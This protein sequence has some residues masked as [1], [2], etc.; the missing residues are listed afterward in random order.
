MEK[1]VVENVGAVKRLEIPVP[2]G[3]GVV[4]F[5]GRNGTGKSTTISAVSSLLQGKGAPLPTLRDGAEKGSV[6]GFGAC[7]NLSVESRRRGGA[8]E[9]VVDNVEGKFSIDKLVDPD[10]QSPEAADR[11]RIKALVTLTGKKADYHDFLELFNSEDEF[12]EI[13]SPASLETNDPVEMGRRIKADLDKSAKKA[14]TEAERAQ[15]EADILFATCETFDKNDIIADEKAFQQTLST[16]FDRKTSLKT[17][18]QLY[19]GRRFEVERA[20]RNIAETDVLEQE[21]QLKKCESDIHLLESQNEDSKN[22][23]AERKEWIR[24]AENTIARLRQEVQSEEAMMASREG[25]ITSHRRTM[26]S[27]KTTLQSLAGWR[28]IIEREK[29]LEPVSEEEVT[30]AEKEYE[31]LREKQYRSDKAKRI[32]EEVE[33]AK[34]V[35]DESQ[36]WRDTATTLRSMGRQC[37]LIL[38][39]L[40]GEDCPIRIVDGRL[41]VETNRGMTYFSEL[42][43]G[44]RWRYAFQA[45]AP[46]IRKGTRIGI[47]T[48]PQIG[49]ESLDPDNQN[50]VKVLAKEYGIV[51]VTAEA[52]ADELHV[53]AEDKVWE[54]ELPMAS[55]PV[56]EREFAKNRFAKLPM[57]TR[58]VAWKVDG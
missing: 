10:I 52:T 5:K 34:R 19:E 36:F 46:H 20:K 12:R 48:I 18:K 50:L 42:S 33:K 53:E 31:E 40:I 28:E 16:A 13:V 26:V 45:V 41:K 8:S 58:A 21:S 56:E 43:D 7:I 39:K 4:V 29:T 47:L 25:E 55:E 44:E 14:E 49:W 38:S 9:I 32:R 1:I 6:S 27:I 17:K 23:I 22:R 35:Q 2:E 54:S 37:D 3:G 11:Q 30:A 24:D 57:K 51:V 15:T